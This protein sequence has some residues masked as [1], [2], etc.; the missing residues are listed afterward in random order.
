MGF[1]SQQTADLSFVFTRIGKED[2]CHALARWAKSIDR[3]RLA[4]TGAKL[5]P[6]R[7]D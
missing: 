2:V 5:K 1:Y 6:L 4:D 3:A 7:V